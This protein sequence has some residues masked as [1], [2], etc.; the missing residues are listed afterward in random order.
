M[1]VRKKSYICSRM[2]R[3]ID[4]GLILIVFLL[5]CLS[6][7]A[8]KAAPYVFRHLTTANGLS[9]NEVTVI[10]RDHQGF[11]WIG[12]W[13]GLLC[14]DGHH[15]R[16]FAS[17]GRDFGSLP[18]GEIESIQEDASG[19]VWVGRKNEYVVYRR[20][21]GQFVNGVQVLEELRLPVEPLEQVIV[22]RQGDL[23]VVISRMMY[24]YDADDGNVAEMRLPT[25]T[26]PENVAVCNGQVVIV[27]KQGRLFSRSLQGGGWRKLSIEE[28][29]RRLNRVYFDE[30]GRLWTYS[31]LSD[32]LYLQEG[33]RWRLIPLK[34]VGESHIRQILDDHCGSIWIATDHN[35]LFLYNKQS[36]QTENVCH[37]ETDGSTIAEDNITCL[38]RDDDYTMWVGHEKRGLSYFNA[39]FKRFINYQHP[40]L[41]NLSVALE[42]RRGI[43][44]IGTDGQGLIR[45]EG[46]QEGTPRYSHIDVPGNTVV[47][48]TEDTT[49][50]LWIGT[51][52]NGLLCYDGKTMRQYTQS[53]SPL[54]DNSVYSLCQ[55][56]RGR[57]WVGTLWGHLQCFD[58]DTPLQADRWT[59]YRSDNYPESMATH[60][61]VDKNGDVL[62]GMLLGMARFN[63]T[64][65][66]WAKMQGNERGTQAFLQQKMQSVMRDRRGLLWLCHE[67]GISVW[68]QQRD[69]LYYLTK[70]EG[71]CD[72]MPRGIVEDN[73][74]RVWVT[75]TNGCS[76]ISVSRE[77]ERGYHFE[78]NNYQMGNELGENHFSLHGVCRL[79][80][81]D[82]L[83]CTD[84]GFTIVNMD[85]FD[86]PANELPRVLITG[87][88]VGGR[89]VS[90]TD[91]LKLKYDDAQ[92]EVMF[93]DMD[94]TGK[95]HI[96]YVYRIEGL[97][98]E[99]NTTDRGEVTIGSLQPG[100]YTLL[101]KAVNTDDGSESEAV[102]LH[103]D[104]A[105]PFWLSWPALLLYVLLVVA[106]LYWWWRS[107]QN[108]QR[109]RMEAQQQRLQQEQLM[110]LS[111]MKMR[112][113]TNVSHDFRTPLTLVLTPLQ[114]LME[115]TKDSALR[116]R[117]NGIYFNANKLLRLVNQLLDFKK[118]DEGREM[119]QPTPG[120]F[121]TFVK[122]TASAFTDYAKERQIDF[123]VTAQENEINIRFDKDKIGKVIT[124][125][126][127]NAFKYTPD[128][129][130]IIIS[131]MTADGQAIVSVA[132]TGIG[133]ADAEKAHV[134]ERFYQ[135]DQPLEKTG[136]GIGLH[137]VK[138]YITLHHGT[139]NVADNKPNGT[140]FTFSIP[141]DFVKI[142]HEEAEG[143][144]TPPDQLSTSNAQRSTLLLVEDNREFREFMRDSLSDTYNILT[145]GDGHEALDILADHDPNMIITDVMMP[146]MD[147]V[148]LCTRVKTNLKWSHIPVVML[149]ALSTDENRL[150]S[151][152]QGADEYITKPFNLSVLRLR[153]EKI[154]EWTQASRSRFVEKLEV[155]P[156]EIT[157]TPLDE[158]LMKKAIQI[159]E[160][161]MGDSNFSVVQLG[162]T[163]GMSR[164]NLYKKLMAITGMGPSDFIRTMRLKRACQLL[165][166]SQLQVSEIAYTVGYNSPKVFSQSFKA[167]YGMTPSEYVK[168]LRNDSQ[169]G[170]D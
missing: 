168:S 39:S 95:H 94:L 164:N 83:F 7:G 140:V 119:L 5:V 108:R 76:T 34:G 85:I 114:A 30:D 112:F 104:V 86:Q 92:I 58:A 74:G 133:I 68:D 155:E 1:Q 151:L 153:I 36:R 141:A 115:E 11:L 59:D 31:A 13:S 157:I 165:Q 110:R 150:K 62:A 2:T 125:L 128:N 143:Q 52:L 22:D 28:G 103:I 57:I 44:W 121:V 101:I 136:S 163:L 111:E 142:Q 80:N 56:W 51:Y 37:D 169:D 102:A 120:N 61:T 161:H 35:G 135:A 170:R 43:V 15:M 14:Y 42:D 16:R 132:D 148:E 99:W 47:C 71:L 73:R 24:H 154:I 50:R 4:R 38:C 109:Q 19:N 107:A 116:R 75:T 8:Q 17:I 12:T 84:A 100:S 96:H 66:E 65:G 156:A 23:L 40:L 146:V 167:E 87:I 126:L 46:L 79:S 60:L 166:K 27:D 26:A 122:D 78:V 63:T 117:L 45:V 77:N 25:E 41:K 159:V 123:R 10:V 93:S 69:T 54:S 20:E 137:I 49:G 89:E 162:D 147:G 82:L 55:D 32:R 98:K 29:E 18:E 97:S 134:F 72:N 131:M 70:N 64:T 67:M 160:E 88:K 138:E 48:M 91:R 113:F 6:V 152:K 106:L 3:C 53:N 21:V 158:Q 145:A 118:L 130:T 127:S 149:T 139:I 81:G 90:V 33:E 144:E 9:N 105:S 129:G 124:N